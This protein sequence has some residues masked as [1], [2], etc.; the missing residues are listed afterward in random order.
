MNPEQVP[1]LLAEIALADPRVRREDPIERRAQVLMW[2]GILVD[3]PYEYAVTAA[4]KHY[5]TSKWPILPADIATRWQATVRDRMNRDA[6]PEPP[7]VDPDDEQAYRTG[8]A[9]RRQAVA[10][11]H[12]APVGVPELVAPGPELRD[13]LNHIGRYVPDAIREQLGPIWPR[14]GL[15]GALSHRCPQCGARPGQRCT[16]PK[17]GTRRQQPHGARTSHTNA[18]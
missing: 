8:L 13:R 15:D 12:T 16:S 11:G 4:Q 7:G 9:T 5:A 1:Q 3:V 10:L 2:A 17:S 18:A 14:R 6:D